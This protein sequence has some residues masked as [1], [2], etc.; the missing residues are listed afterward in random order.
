MTLLTLL[1]SN[2]ILLIWER[3][4]LHHQAGPAREMLRALSLTSIRIVLFPREARLLP[5]LIDGLNQVLAEL[6]VKL[7]GTG[8]IRRIRLCGF[9][10]HRA[11]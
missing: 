6:A 8:S 3:H 10:Y 1:A 2:Q 5:A 9:L 11:H 4:N 7:L